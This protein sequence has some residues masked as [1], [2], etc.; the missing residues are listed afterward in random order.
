MLTMQRFIDRKAKP[1]T[2]GKNNVRQ[3]PSRKQM[4]HPNKITQGTPR[5]GSQYRDVREL[6]GDHQG[7]I[8]QD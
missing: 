5:K 1:D 4:A 8:P 2:I 6:Q 3:C 7:E